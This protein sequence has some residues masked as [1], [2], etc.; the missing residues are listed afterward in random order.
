MHG[1]W[2]GCH[3]SS[4]LA[5][6]LP[7]PRPHGVPGSG[8]RGAKRGRRRVL[9]RALS[10]ASIRVVRCTRA[11]Y[12]ARQARRAGGMS[13]VAAASAAAAGGVS[14]LRP[15]VWCSAGAASTPP[16]PAPAPKA[17]AK[18]S[19]PASGSAERSKSAPACRVDALTPP[20]DACSCR[21]RSAFFRAHSA[22]TQER[23]PTSCLS[24]RHPRRQ[25][26][27]AWCVHRSR[28]ACPRASSHRR[29]VKRLDSR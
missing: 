3:V 14:L 4:S 6:A 10:F 13:L 1:S 15:R 11:A 24:P 2:R 8:E 29:F 20:A 22:T 28:L 23:R 25:A 18:G 12:T 16:Q 19:A 7:G 17:R 26:H 5:R 9:R 21:V 27:A